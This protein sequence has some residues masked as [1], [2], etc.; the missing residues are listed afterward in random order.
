M[1]GCFVVDASVAAKWFLGDEKDVALAGRLLTGARTGDI[2]L[3]APAIF[4]H[5]VCNLLARAC[6][7]YLPPHRQPRLKLEQALFGVYGVFGAPVEL[8][9]FTPRE[10]ML[11]LEYAVCYHKAFDDMT[12]LTL[13]EKLNCMWVTADE[14]ILRACPPGFP[15]HRVLPLAA[16]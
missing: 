2:T 10:A 9:A 7:T 4:R 16:L 14:K 6:G 5:E 11:A 13:A 12:Y 1:N 8:E 15:A 3:H